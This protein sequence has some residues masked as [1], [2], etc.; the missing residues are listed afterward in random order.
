MPTGFVGGSEALGGVVDATIVLLGAGDTGEVGAALAVCWAGLISA[1]FGKVGAAMPGLAAI[2][3]GGGDEE[4]EA[5]IGVGAG[6]GA[7]DADV[8][9][10][11][12]GFAVIALGAGD[13]LADD[14][15]GVETVVGGV[16]GVGGLIAAVV[17]APAAGARPAA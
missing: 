1:G 12:P 7:V 17:P 5:I 3:L 15:V 16:D 13:E 2:V 10:A 8:G 6:A 4:A 9:E 11:V 14:A